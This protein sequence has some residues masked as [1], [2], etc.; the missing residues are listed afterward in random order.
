MNAPHHLDA[1]VTAA[2][3][4]AADQHDEIDLAD[5]WDVLVDNRWLIMAAVAAAL[6]VGVGYAVLARP[7]Y[8]SNLLIQVEDPAGPDGSFLGAAGSLV[9]VKTSAAA[10][11]EIVQSRM[12]VGQAVDSTKLYL[13]AGPH[14]VPVVGHW[15]A[16]RATTL[17]DPGFLGY[18]GLVSGTE[19]I[20]VDSFEVPQSMEGLRFALTAR[21]DG[22][23]ALTHPSLREDLAGRVGAPLVRSTPMGTISLLV[24]SIEGRPGAEF[25]LTR[26]SRLATI[27]AV[28]ASLKLAEKGQQSGMI[29]ATLRWSEPGRAALILNEI[30]AQYVRQ[31]VERKVAE[32]QKMLVFLDMQLPE[33]KKQLDRSEEAYTQYRKEQG[34]V[35][36]DHETSLVLN[37]T[38][39]LQSKLLAAQQKRRELASR[40]TASHPAV[41][42]LDEQIVAWNEESSSLTARMRRLPVVQQEAIR[43][44]RDIKVNNEAYQGLRNNA[45][46]L[47]LIREG[48]VG[49]VRVIDRAEIPQGFVEPRRSVVLGAAASLGLLAG[50]LLALARNA[51]FRGIRSSH[52]IEA[53]TGLSV[54]STIPLSVRQQALARK[55]AANL[56]GVHLLASVA[57]DDAAIES[58]RSLRISLQ[59]A[60][61]ESANN[62]VLVTGA[63]A[64]VGKSFI[65]ANFAAVLA[66]AG[67]RVLLVDADLRKG[68]LHLLFGVDRSRGLSELVAGSLR[69]E[70]AIHRGLLPNLDLLTTGILPPNPAEL[71]MSG[72][73]VRVLDELSPRY[74]VVI[75]DTPP[76][77]LAA[78]TIGMA[79]QVGT[80]LLV[81][82]AGQTQMGEL[83][84]AA[85]RVLL[86]GKRVS[87][88]LFNAIDLRRRHY[89]G[90]GYKS[91]GYG[92]LHAYRSQQ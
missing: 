18:Q 27:G 51:F 14:Y 5:Y 33:F 66:S 31:N 84:E 39:D 73:F 15:L 37:R 29:N 76:V 32:A 74:D 72:A 79:A 40:F 92:Y 61:L 2:A 13:E 38:E 34:T 58:L 55:A 70:E 9:N 80:L 46:Q 19:R 20:T 21:G 47:Q 42:T 36:L 8:E 87:G 28:Q 85:K 1:G 75:M 62:R 71:M 69:P 57:P 90:Y 52:Q 64:G 35:A 91:G 60:M 7:V 45:L 12:V 78:D 23:Y 50:V 48:K 88:V 81:A 11:I 54:Y 89:G 53:H 77:L 83:H 43:L 24:S 65:S 10:E 30:A 56:R 26:N 6:A 3:A 86:A 67:K 68:H 49:N 63:T 22:Q 82:R 25:H 59:F 16:R 4:S 41:K 17:S 44:E